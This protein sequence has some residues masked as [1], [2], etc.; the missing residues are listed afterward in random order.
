MARLENFT[1]DSMPEDLQTTGAGFLMLENDDHQLLFDWLEINE[2]ASSEH[3]ARLTGRA[4]LSSANVTL[5]YSRTH[6]NGFAS[7]RYAG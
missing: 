2:Q 6:D 5:K 7:F 4:A 3:A 1:F